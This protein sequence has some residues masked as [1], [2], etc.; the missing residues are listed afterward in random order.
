M[1]KTARKALVAVLFL[2]L[3]F[4]SFSSLFAV[5]RDG[6]TKPP[7]RTYA[8]IADINTEKHTFDVLSRDGKKTTT[9]GIT[10]FTKFV[11]NGKTA[12]FDDLK[13]D[14]R[15]DVSSH[16]DKTATRVDA[17]DPPGEKTGGEGKKK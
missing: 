15:V 2:S 17:D 11:V 6:P 7:P 1:M 12:K 4:A 13:K 10:P 14:M 16:D 8:K 5:D 9:Y 3:A